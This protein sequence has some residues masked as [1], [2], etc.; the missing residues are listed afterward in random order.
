[1]DAKESQL[2]EKLKDLL[3]RASLVAAE[4][5]ALQQGDRVPHFD[6]I[7]LPAHALGQEFSRMI[8]SERVRS[9]AASGLEDATCPDCGSRHA[10]ETQTR[11]IHSM[12]GPT[13]V[14]ETVAECRRCRRSFFPSTR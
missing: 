9:V 10:V 6:E 3:R 4:I 11:Q 2:D 13:E 7:E 14:T 1:M 12:D 8:Q 5:Q